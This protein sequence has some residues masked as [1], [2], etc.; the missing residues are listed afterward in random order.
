[1]LQIT[2]D[3]IRIVRVREIYTPPCV[4]ERPL[5][6]LYEVII[7]VHEERMQVVHE[8]TSCSSL[9]RSHYQCSDSRIARAVKRLTTFESRI[10]KF[11]MCEGILEHK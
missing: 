11:L 6:L 1:M 9:V 4:F 8:E 7:V 5:C 3:C 2:S 10:F